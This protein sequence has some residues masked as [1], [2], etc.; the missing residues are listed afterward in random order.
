MNQ[1]L[2][3]KIKFAHAKRFRQIA[4]IRLRPN[5]QLISVI[6]FPDVQHERPS[7]RIV[8]MRD[9]TALRS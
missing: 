7:W 1:F 4:A 5:T 9:G 3:K 8:G 2:L 6:L